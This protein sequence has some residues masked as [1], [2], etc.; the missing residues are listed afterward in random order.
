MG[1]SKGF[2]WGVATADYQIEGAYNEDGKG[3]GIWDV[4]T[5]LPDKV[6][7]N[8]NGDIACD[9]YHRFKEDIKLMKEIGV[10]NYRF[11]IS[12]VRILPDG[13]GKVNEKGLKFYSDLVDELLSNGIEPLVT[14]YHWNF[15]NELHRK[16]GWLNRESSDWFARF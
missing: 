7:N 2:L 6:D 11:A 15:P 4:Y 9:H 12:W 3:L 1:F 13:I 8:E 14:L 5:R 16:G 10:K